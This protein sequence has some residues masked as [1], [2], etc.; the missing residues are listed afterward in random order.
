MYLD[1][2]YASS[3]QDKANLLNK[4][5]FSVYSQRTIQPL[6]TSRSHSHSSLGSIAIT[7]LD[8]FY[9]LSS[10][11]PSKALGINCIG[12]KVL[13]NCAIPFCTPVHHLLSVSLSTGHLPNEWCTHFITPIFKAGDKC[14]VKKYR[15]ISLLCT[16][17]KVV[18]C[19]VF[20]HVAD[21]LADH[22]Y[23]SFSV[24]ILEMMVI[25]AAATNYA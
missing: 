19:S 21:F 20:I 13:K 2:S 9:A 12:P 3:D 11:D 14:S 6:L 24:W 15:P 16:V 5:L 10:L 25:A 18:E 8:V 7:I 17:S 22:N 1:S 4:F 23:V